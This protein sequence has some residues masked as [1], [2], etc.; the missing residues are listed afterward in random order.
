MT[1]S[2]A[3]AA[4]ATYLPATRRALDM[5]VASVALRTS[6]PPRAFVPAGLWAPP[7]TVACMAAINV[8]THPA[9]ARADH[10]R[11]EW[12]MPSAV[13]SRLPAT[14]APTL[15][16][17]PGLDRPSPSHVA[18]RERYGWWRSWRR[19]LRA[20]QVLHAVVRPIVTFRMLAELHAVVRA[21]VPKGTSLEAPKRQRLVGHAHAALDRV[22]LIPFF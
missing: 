16:E 8:V 20:T 13:P 9:A 7:P 10:P 22:I 19:T 2:A 12:A 5:H 15:A 17:W 1:S 18:T 6:D 4:G 3:K 21:A 11:A 14:P